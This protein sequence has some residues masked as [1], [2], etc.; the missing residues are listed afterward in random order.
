MV[1]RAYD[2]LIQTCLGLFWL[3]VNVYLKAIRACTAENNL[4]ICSHVGR[5]AAYQRL[6]LRKP[7]AALPAL[8]KWS[9]VQRRT[10]LTWCQGRLKEEN[11]NDWRISS[12]EV[13]ID[14]WPSAYTGDK[15]IELGKLSNKRGMYRRNRTAL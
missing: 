4:R 10:S 9:L 13:R 14:L 12:R 15:Y 3:S 2:W 5:V 7:S 1:H 6:W 8:L 11:I